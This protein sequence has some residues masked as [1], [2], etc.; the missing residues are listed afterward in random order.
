MEEP[1]RASI[2][3]RHGLWSSKRDGEWAGG[4]GSPPAAE[5][6]KFKTYIEGPSPPTQP[7]IRPEPLRPGLG[8]AAA[9][10][11]SRELRAA[12]C[13]GL[14]AAKAGRGGDPARLSEAA[15]AA[16]DW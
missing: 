11:A 4:L 12:G 2:I 16:V 9:D 6:L 5:A 8:V 7:R 14:H 10:L 13:L 15:G 1:P 3:G